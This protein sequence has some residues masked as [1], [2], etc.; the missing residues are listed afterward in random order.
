MPGYRIDDA[1]RLKGRSGARTESLVD[2]ATSGPC[3]AIMTIAKDFQDLI[4]AE[5]PR[6]HDGT[7]DC[8][9]ERLRAA[10]RNQSTSA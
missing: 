3:F 1:G 8:L 2:G 10:A 4:R 5:C 7:G 6:C 9:V